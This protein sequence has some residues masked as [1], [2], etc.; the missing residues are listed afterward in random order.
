MTTK[1]NYLPTMLLTVAAAVSILAAP[2]AL[3]EVGCPQLSAYST[4][5]Q[6]P[7]NAQ[8][9]T[10]PPAQTLPV[11]A[12]YLGANGH[13]PASSAMTSHGEARRR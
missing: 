10:S 7:G 9:T 13:G 5:C 12:P 6:T 2:S 8:I 11:Q 1:R 4:G 3:T